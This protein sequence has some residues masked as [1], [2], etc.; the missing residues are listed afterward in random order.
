MNFKK[1]AHAFLVGVATAA[2]SAVAG[3]VS[4]FDWSQIGTFAAV[5]APLAA[6]AS[7]ALGAWVSTWK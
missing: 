7:R 6:I 2:V 4:G 1:V 3:A 5:V